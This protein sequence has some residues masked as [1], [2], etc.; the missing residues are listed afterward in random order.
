VD[1]AFELNSP[2]AINAWTG[3]DAPRVIPSLQ[4]IPGWALTRQTNGPGPE[5][6]AMVPTEV[7]PWDWRH[8]KVGWGLVLRDNVAI[9]P[10]ARARAEDAPPAIQR[11]LAA[12]LGAPV[13]R[14][15]AEE[16]HARLLRYDGAGNVLPM[17]MVG[18]EP[19]TGPKQLP[20][21]LLI[22][23]SPQT[24]PWAFQYAANLSHYV[25]RIDLD[26]TALENYID[27]LLTDWAGASCD[28]C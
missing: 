1:E 4:R 2:L 5:A 18:S 14:W 20:R 23:A 6:K 11:L 25:G 19:G 17:S 3:S 10:E 27:A 13:L 24:I 12:R 16:G 26:G 9:A 28:P 15:N 22:A 7:P 8:P 21:Y